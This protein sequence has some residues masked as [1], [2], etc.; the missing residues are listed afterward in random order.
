[1]AGDDGEGHRIEVAEIE[2]LD[3]HAV[4][5]REDHDF[6]P[7]LCE[8]ENLARL[9]R[10]LDFDLEF[11]STETRS[12]KY[13]TDIIA[14]NASDG[15]RVII[16]NQFRRSDHDH[17]GKC[18]TYLAAHE[19]SA[20]VWIAESFSEEHRAALTWLNDNT[21]EEVGFFAVAPDVIRIAGS[22]PALDFRV[23][24]SPNSFVKRVKQD[25]QK[26]DASIV[27]TREA[28]WQAFD[29]ELAHDPVLS[30]CVQRYGGKLS[31]KWLI[32]DVGELNGE[33]PPHVLVW[34]NSPSRGSQAVGYAI[35]PQSSAS[36]EIAARCDQAWAAVREEL[37]SSS[38]VGAISG[39]SELRAADLSSDEGMQAAVTDV[40]PRVRAAYKE[41]LQAIDGEQ[42]VPHTGLRG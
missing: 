23:V 25:D 32:P 10:T 3:L 26:I 15:S 24:I 8:A 11:V 13:R 20:I 16:E 22:P 21:P 7:W 39:R 34:L 17:L 29:V 6:T 1:M 19:A 40:L 35:R 38:D 9:S 18:L 14:R 36:P 41:L 33:E 27:P 5:P 37:R 12:S 28:F 30:R 31:F 2:R 42:N 4:F